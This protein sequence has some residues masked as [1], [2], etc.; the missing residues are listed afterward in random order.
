MRTARRESTIF[1]AGAGIFHR[2]FTRLGCVGRPPN[3]HVEFYPYAGLS[4]TIRLRDNMALVRL[5]DMLRQAP[6]SV[7]EAAAA[8]LLARIYRRPLPQ[9]LAAVY[10]RYSD[11]PLTRRRLRRA[12]KRRGCRAHTGPQGGFHHLREI[13]DGVNAE[14][15]EANLTAPEI[16]W[17]VRP[18]KRQ[19]GVF[20]PGLG[21]IVINRRLDRKAVPRMVVAYVVFHE[22]LHLRQAAGPFRCGLG[23]HSP[24]F[25][26]EEKRFRE[27][28]RAR[29]FLR[30]N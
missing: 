13:F 6:L 3:F 25:R 8:L 10:R 4:H 30:V 1:P 11:S 21:H 7:L 2:M 18:W 23:A 20:D 24:E 5:S 27:Y 28:E 16:G 9:S 22:M 12:R 15:F 17:S 19:L 26:R 14:Y 29:R